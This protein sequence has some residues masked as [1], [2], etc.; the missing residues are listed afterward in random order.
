MFGVLNFLLGGQVIAI[1][2]TLFSVA[3]LSG[4][5]VGFSFSGSIFLR[6][7]REKIIETLLC[8]PLSLKSI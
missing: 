2:N 1:D 8:T 4:V 7:K 3:M 6:E 5:F